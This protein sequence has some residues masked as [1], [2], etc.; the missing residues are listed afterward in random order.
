MFSITSEIV[1]ETS[2]IVSV[3]TANPMSILIAFVPENM[4]AAFST[5]QGVLSVVFIAIEL[6]M[7]RNIDEKAKNFKRVIEEANEIVQLFINFLIN[8]V[9]IAIFSLIVRAFALYGID[10]IKP[11]LIYMVVTIGVLLIYLTVGYALI[12]VGN[13]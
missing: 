12:V 11:V 8:K 3:D 7:Y 2:N 5:N 4:M 13:N 9:D 6:S 10:Q 1:S